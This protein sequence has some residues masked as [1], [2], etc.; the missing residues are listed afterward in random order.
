MAHFIL[1]VMQL[2]LFLTAFITRFI[3]NDTG[4]TGSVRFSNRMLH[5][6]RIGH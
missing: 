1:R 5:M 4:K 6:E 2:L 3:M